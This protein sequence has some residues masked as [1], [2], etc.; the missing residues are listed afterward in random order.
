M[1]IIVNARPHDVSATDLQSALHELGFACSSVATA[2][3]GRFV[4][5]SN[6]EDV[7]LTEGDH[8]EVLAPM[9]GG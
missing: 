8:L 7:Q 4:A 3:N 2:L 5:R 6:R 9:Q 1:K